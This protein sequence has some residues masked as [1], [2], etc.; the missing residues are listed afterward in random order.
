V[1]FECY[2]IGDLLLDAGTQEVMRN[3][4]A[5]PVPRLSFKLLLSLARHAP[6]V[7]STQE[8]EEDVWSGLVVD[9][10]TINKRVLLLRKALGEDTGCGPYIT[11][12]RGSGYRMDIPVTR[13]SDDTDKSKSE[14]TDDPNLYQRTSGA[15][16]T[17]SYWLLGIVAVLALYQGLR[18]LSQ[19][20]IQPEVHQNLISQTQ[21]VVNYDRQSVAVHGWSQS[22]STYIFICISEYLAHCDGNCR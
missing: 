2:R 18:E 7:V 14:S 17:A 16:R 5:V 8:L 12:I 20:P 1:G 11:V 21:T 15:V 9:K 19:D 6:N 10:G 4:E 3:G 22:G 13:L